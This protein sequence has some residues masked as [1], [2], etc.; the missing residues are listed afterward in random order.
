[1]KKTIVITGGGTLGHILPIIPVIKDLTDDCN[2]VFIGTKKGLE[3]NYLE[4][5]NLNSLFKNLYFFDMNGINRKNIFNNIVTFIKYFKIRKK[6]KKVYKLNKPSLV[7]GM[8]GYISGVS[9]Y[10]ANK[11]KIKTIIH[12]QNSVLG[13]ANKLVYKKVNYLL[14][15]F[16]IKSLKG[17]NIKVVGNPRYSDVLDNYSPNDYLNNLL[18][19][20]GS[21]GSKKINDIIINNIEKFKNINVT[22]ITGN[23]YFNENIIE[24]NN[25]MSIY[26][27]VKIF[28]FV[29]ELVKMMSNSSIIVSRSG[30]TT[31]NEIMALKKCAILIP[32][33]NVT[34]NHQYYNALFLKEQNACILIEEKDLSDEELLKSIF[35]LYNNYGYKKQLQNN[36]NNIITNNP[37]KDFIEIIRELI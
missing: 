9:I 16:P 13:L 22:L 26:K 25:I 3:K 31:L 34:Q 27:N 5:N 35:L 1:M 17:D 32:S 18:V 37:K 30:A 33:P 28:P 23:K 20:G 10:I 19:V 29:N 36:L 15:S 24:I 14:L 6:I 7:I 4:N 2:F 8:G 21:L 12:E 11:M